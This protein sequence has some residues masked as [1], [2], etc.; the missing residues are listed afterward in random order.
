MMRRH[1]LGRIFVLAAALAALPALSLAIE[2]Q[3]LLTSD[4]TVHVVR[5]GRVVDLGIQDASLSP[6]DVVIEWASR[7]Q[8]GTL[9][10]EIIP[11]TESRGGKRGLQ[12]AFDEQTQ[13]LL[14][15]W[16]EDISAFSEIRVGVLHAG[17]WTNAGL[18]PNQGISRAF[19]PQMRVTHQAVKYLDDQDVEV[20][21][22]SSILSILWWEEA[23]HGQARL[24]TLFLD[25]NAFDPASLSIYDLPVLTG[26]GG[27]VS[28]EG[29]P[30]GAY[31]FPSL[32]PDGL[33]G[34][35][36]VSYADLHDQR[37]KVVR[38]QFPEDQ[39]KPSEAGNLK[40]KRRHIPIVGIAS[41]GPVSRMTPIVAQNAGA[42][43]SV[44]T[45]IG[46]GYMPTL[47][48]REGDFLKYS[49]LEGADWGAVRSIA[50]DASMPYE[51]ALELVTGMGER[52]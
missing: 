8:D 47:Y 41:S 2:E 24:A 9:S 45:S 12:A 43:L 40:W 52:R 13:T 39:G 18:L 16:T 51:R 22:T 20:S 36:L 7:A 17:V 1:G 28:Y 23:Q 49:R 5:A 3:S 33:S 11:G 19:N 27:E 42:E 14:L 30:S 37:H 6:E 26:G 29:V 21:K 15:L 25:E 4:G 38:V 31:L 50:I 44:G 35:F 32:Q 34:A 48:W 10:V 46:S